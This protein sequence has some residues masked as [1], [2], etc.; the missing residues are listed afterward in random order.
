MQISSPIAGGS[1]AYIIH[2]MLADGIDGYRVCAYNPWLTALPPALYMICRQGHPDLIHTTPD[3]SFFSK[4]KDTPLVITFHNYVLD[5]WMRSYSSPLQRL[6]YATDLKWITRLSV[7]RA[8]V[9][10]AVSHFTADQV[11]RELGLQTRVRVIYNG[12][13]EHSFAPRKRNTANG[14]KVR[15]LFSGNLIPRKGSDLLPDIVDRLNPGI[16]LL[17]TTG[18]RSKQRLPDHPSV[19][20]VG[21]VAFEDMPELYNSVDILLF[22][23]IREGFGLAAAEA[24]AC[25]LPVVTTDCSA[26]P[27]LVDH[28]KGGMLCPPGDSGAF[29]DSINQLADSVSLRRE[30]GEYNRARVEQQFT[31]HR[32]IRNYISLFEETLDNW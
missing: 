27:E 14:G 15:V 5:R 7:A 20:C 22:P 6:H 11:V 28:G 2:Q 26:L 30:M 31:A 19:K 8:D 16:E 4:R 21:Q 3:Y 12:V 9:I 13:D 23:T 25:G 1:G 10:T 24:M 18:L 17:Y 29:A 32:M